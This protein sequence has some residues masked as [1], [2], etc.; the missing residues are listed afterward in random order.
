MINTE[1]LGR[2][3]KKVTVG[4]KI[5]ELCIWSDNQIYE[6][7][8]KVYNK[9]PTFKG[10]AFPTTISVNEVCGY[11]SPLQEDSSSIKEG[12]L[13]KLELGVH[14]DG[15]AAFAAHTVVVQSDKNAPITGRKADVILAAYKSAQAALRLMKPGHTNNEVTE[16]IQKISNAYE[17]SPLE[18]VLSHELKKHLIDG[19]KVII[20]KETFEQ[21]VDPQEFAVHDVFA[22]D[23][24]VSSGEGKPKE[25]DLRCTVYKRALDRSYNLKIKQSRQFFNDVL[26][27]YPSFCFSLNSF[28]DPITARIGIKECLEHELLVPF[29]ILVEKPGNLVAQFKF[30][31]MIT[32][33]KTTALTGLPI[34]EAQF[35]TEHEIK[36]QAILDL[37]AVSIFLFSNLW[38]RLSRRRRRRNSRNPRLDLYLNYLTTSLYRI[39]QRHIQ[40][41]AYRHQENCNG[42][43][44]RGGG[45]RKELSNAGG[46]D[47]VVGA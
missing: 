12:D 7:I 30:T 6:E 36:D 16:V 23:V 2:L 9:K 46:V 15:F 38:T 47:V 39:M 44:G 18:G 40:I 4:S 10:L 13:V 28:E 11:N 24:F 31:V 1:V 43:D 27:R 34:D 22:L 14:I 26:D 29:P 45:G 41:S 20:N 35:K 3:I 32:K 33:G 42:C 8:T 37:L 19:N 21:R 17:V 5:F 25:S